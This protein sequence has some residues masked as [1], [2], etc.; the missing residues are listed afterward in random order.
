MKLL[1]QADNIGYVIATLLKYKKSV[2]KLL[3]IPFHRE[4]KNNPGH[5]FCRFF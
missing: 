4:F 1:K 3:Q 5:I 2:C